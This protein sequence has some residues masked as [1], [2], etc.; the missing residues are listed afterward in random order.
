MSSRI[1]LLR[2]V[3]ASVFAKATSA[4]T[5]VASVPILINFLGVESYATWLVI[6]AIPVW[7]SMADIGLGSVAANEMSLRVSRGDW[8]GAER[9]FH[10]TLAAMMALLAFGGVV[11]LGAV[12]LLPLG[13][14]LGVDSISPDQ[15]RFTLTILG[16][17]SLISLQGTLAV[18]LL[19]A[20]Q[21]ADLAIWI[22][23]TKPLVDLTF[24]LIALLIGRDLYLLALSLMLSQIAFTLGG[25][26][27]G[28]KL[29]PNIRLGFSHANASDIKYCL[30]KGVAFCTLPLSNASVLQ[31]TTLIVNHVLGGP[32]VVIFNTCR[33]MMRVSQQ[34]MNLLG[35]SFW[36]EFSHLV[37]AGDLRR[38]RKLH[39]IL[40]GTNLLLA[41]GVAGGIL[42]FGPYIYGV[43]TAN[44][45]EVSRLLLLCF[46]MGVVA[47]ALWFSGSVVV[48][49]ANR[50]EGYAMAYLLGCL[51][52]LPACLALTK[53]WGLYGA[54]LS[55]L[56]ADLFVIP[57]I[58]HRT[59]VITEE[60]FL[61]LAKETVI[62][63]RDFVR[64]SIAKLSAFLTKTAS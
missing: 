31:G 63:T 58:F 21:R 34:A 52:S 19:R 29:C 27:F 37:G 33:T 57:V 2:N 16:F 14:W 20:V 41:L 32:W 46:A 3:N 42:I 7:L 53:S 62:S 50:H 64:E 49:A 1:R 9:I 11:V 6:S 59:L 56:V 60:S 45:L 47:N 61:Q 38:L 18:G 24:T 35:Q 25:V 22:S 4:L 12:S 55:P 48:S 26:A 40:L 43:W 5:S 8:L 54:A 30:T 44:K 10:S 39:H 51:A 17:S 28:L 13:P 36:P 23:G 15:L